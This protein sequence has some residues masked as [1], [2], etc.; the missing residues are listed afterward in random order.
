MNQKDVAFISVSNNDIDTTSNT[1]KV[2]IALLS[3]IAEFE[4]DIIAERVTDNMYELAKEGRWLGGKCPLGYH[5]KQEQYTINGKKTNISHL[6]PVLDEQRVVKKLYEVF[7]KASS[8]KG[9]AEELNRLDRL[10][11]DGVTPNEGRFTT[12]EGNE[13][14]DNGVRT[15]LQNPVY[16]IADADMKAYFAALEVMV[17]A[18][19]EDFDSKHGMAYNKIEQYKEMGVDSTALE[20]TYVKKAYRRDVDDWIISIGKH[21]GLISGADWIKAQTII[22]AISTSHSGRPK[23]SSK[24]LLSGKVRCVLCGSKM[25]VRAESNRYTP[26]GALRFRYMC[27]EKRLK[28]DGGCNSTDVPGNDLDKIIVEKICA[29]NEGDN[30]FFDEL[31]NTKSTLSV[32]SKETEKEI[33]ALKKRLNQI[34][35]DIQSQTASLREAPERVKKSIFADIEALDIEREAKQERLDAIC[36]DSTE[37]VNQ[38]ADIEKAKRAIMDFPRLMELVDYRASCNC[39]NRYWNVSSSRTIPSTYSSKVP[40]HHRLLRRGQEGVICVT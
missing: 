26:E 9:T 39:Y 29:M 27:E 18:E 28:K 33:V 32:K 5:N 38:L 36:E 30:S 4:R 8:I 6:E 15:I 7:L 22:E 17:H 34:E 20:L 2:M 37:Q 11:I 1:G 35:R 40:K 21:R 14:R 12:N 25:N 16:A 10:Y 24:A 19:D 13:F 31:L 3:A 23:E